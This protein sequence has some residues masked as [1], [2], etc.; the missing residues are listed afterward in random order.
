VSVERSSHDGAERARH[1]L[2]R[3]D[4]QVVHKHLLGGRR[5]DELRALRRANDGRVSAGF[6]GSE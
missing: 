6:R 1:I 2:Q 4:G 5:S 3:H